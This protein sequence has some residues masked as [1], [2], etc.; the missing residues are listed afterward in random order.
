MEN[1]PTTPTK[2]PLS[3]A[4]MRDHQQKMRIQN[5]SSPSKRSAHGTTS[6]N[7]GSRRKSMSETVESRASGNESESLHPS[8]GI[9]SIESDK[10]RHMPPSSQC[11]ESFENAEIMVKT[12]SSCRKGNSEPRKSK[13]LLRRSNMKPRSARKKKLGTSR[14]L[15]DNQRPSTASGG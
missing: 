4:R 2:C 10:S 5:E 7:S 3:T 11:S 14:S 1:N 12:H 13:Q 15:S 6:N 8:G 9:K